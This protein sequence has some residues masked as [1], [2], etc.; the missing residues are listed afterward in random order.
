MAQSLVPS[1]MFM[2]YDISII[3]MRSNVQLIDLVK[4][5]STDP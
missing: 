4:N 1:T 5:F 3:Q 2:V